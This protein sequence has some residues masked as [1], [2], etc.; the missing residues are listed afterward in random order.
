[1]SVQ[2]HIHGEVKTRPGTAGGTNGGRGFSPSGGSMFQAEVATGALTFQII[3]QLLCVYNQSLSVHPTANIWGQEMYKPLIYCW[4][5][6]SK[7]KIKGQ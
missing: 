4:Y 3:L 2:T 1:M 5:F 7:V 6:V